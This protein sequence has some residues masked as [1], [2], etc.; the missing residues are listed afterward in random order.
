MCRGQPPEGSKETGFMKKTKRQGIA[1]ILLIMILLSACGKGGEKQK[2]AEDVT[3]TPTPTLV[4]TNTPTPT[5]T[6]TPTPRPAFGVTTMSLYKNRKDEKLRRKYD[7]T[8]QARWVAGTDITSFE[9]I[10]SDA[11][12]IPNNDR[13]FQDLWKDEWNKFENCD[14]C[15]IGYRVQFQTVDGQKFDKMILKPG[16]EKDYFDYIENYLYDD[17]H[18]VKG[19]WYSHLEP[20]QISDNM[21]LSSMK[22][23]AGKKIDQVMSPITVSAY[24]YYSDLDFD[25]RGNYIGAVS[26]TVQMVNTD[27]NAKYLP[28]YDGGY[29]TA[30]LE[31]DAMNNP[32][33]EEATAVAISITNSNGKGTDSLKD[34]KYSTRVTYN[35]GDTVTIKS[36]S[37]MAGIY[38]I[39]GSPVVPYTVK[40]GGREISCGANGYLH[41]YIAFDA[42]VRECT[43]TISGE[44]SICD[45]YAYS[46]G[47]LPASVQVW[48]PP[49]ENADIVIFSTH[50]DDEVLFFGGV[51]TLYGGA[52][53]KRVQVVYLCNYWDGDRVREH[54]KLDGLWTMGLRAYPVNMPYGDYY[55]KT[56]ADAKNLY[57]YTK[58]LASVTENIRRFKPLIIVT[59]DAK[60]EYGHG[61]HML[62]HAAVVEAIE[63]SMDAEF[64]PES[65]TKYGTWDV[66]KTYIHLYSKNTVKLDLRQHETRLGGQTALDTTKAAY[67]KHETQQ[68]C[69]F[70]VSDEYEYSCA[71]FGLYR[72]TVGYNVGNDM[73]EH[74]I[75]YGDREEKQRREVAR[76]A[77][78]TRAAE[79]TKSAELTQAAE[80]LIEEKIK[81]DEKAKAQNNPASERQISGDDTG[82]SKNKSMWK[83]FFVIFLGITLAFAALVGILY[84]YEV[85][86]DV[87]YFKRRKAA[88]EKGRRPVRHTEEPESDEEDYL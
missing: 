19:Q 52:M 6:P 51:A 86:R 44:T 87:R 8:F 73:F 61:G 68:W 64:N 56:L 60:G 69:W 26:Y 31:Q 16:D 32:G 7:S 5:M 57:S 3:D 2:K 21:I 35:A 84:G 49:Y 74:L 45:I 1:L 58:V 53:G 59:H 71:D 20:E 47:R 88:R 23:T 70:Y 81:E 78:L 18:Q 15:K 11:D 82:K 75:S 54:E 14:Q 28:D 24:I 25:A 36:E 40:A 17:I 65:V 50:A 55:A 72:T 76:V 41:D 13:Y 79:L 34:K 43:V 22:F 30:I 83:T 46:A 33:G 27:I 62:L 67:K 66:P 42:P 12:E 4:P 39:W 9:C 29:Q 38:M 80:K 85:L 63:K 37:D 77:E 10:A 48:N